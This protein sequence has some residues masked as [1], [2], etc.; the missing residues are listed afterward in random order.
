VAESLFNYDN[1]IGVWLAYDIGLELTDNP[2]ASVAAAGLTLVA[3]CGTGG[4]GNNKTLTAIL[5][6]GALVSSSYLRAGILLGLSLTI[7]QY[8]MLG[9]PAILWRWRRTTG[10]QGMVRLLL[11]A[12]GVFLLSYLPLA[13]WGWESV[14]GGFK[15]SYGI[16]IAYLYGQEISGAIY[17]GTGG[18]ISSPEKWASYAVSGSSHIT[19][20][21]ITSLI[22]GIHWVHNTTTS[23]NNPER[24]TIMVGLW[25]LAISFIPMLLVRSYIHYW[26]FFAVILG[27]L[28]AVGIDTLFD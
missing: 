8:A 10:I 7:V 27:P 4:F 19:W 2:R 13:Y 11:V 6:L 3:I 28:S 14:V 20:I 16:G 24:F 15:Y 12:T 23:E 26:A 18:I 25:F 9:I 1:V 5:V 17:S 21:V 22:G